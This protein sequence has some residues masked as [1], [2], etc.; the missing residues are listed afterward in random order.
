MQN[1]NTMADQGIEFESAQELGLN[2]SP[3]SKR[4]ANAAPLGLCAFGLTTFLLSL[5]NLNTRGL[6][7][8]NIVVAS[9][10]AYDGLAQLLAG[11]WDVYLTQFAQT[12]HS[13]NLLGRWRL[14]K[15]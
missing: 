6:S 11:M 15:H 9:A 5:I 7:K 2:K 1:E 13:N 14:A 10:Y 12:E 4:F 3:P 8:P